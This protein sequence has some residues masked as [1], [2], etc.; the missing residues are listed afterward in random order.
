MKLDSS[1]YLYMFI[2]PISTYLTH[3]IICIKPISTYLYM[4]HPRPHSDDEAGLRVPPQTL[5]KEARQL[6]STE[7]DVG[8][9]FVDQ[10]LDAV[11]EGGE[12][13]VDRLGFVELLPFEMTFMGELWCY[14]VTV[15]G[16]SGTV[17]MFISQWVHIF[18]FS[19]HC[20]L[21]TVHRNVISTNW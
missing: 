19:V 13:E 6:R 15:S 21:Y 10:G 16:L 14:G 18:R 20:T 17:K 1:T 7:R 9:V 5:L 11:A 8:N 12:G 2:K 4:F 3:W